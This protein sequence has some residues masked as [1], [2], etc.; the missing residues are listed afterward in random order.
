[1]TLGVAEMVDFGLGEYITQHPSKRYPI[2]TR[3]NAGEVWPEVAYPLTITLTRIVGEEASARAAINAGVI[4][5][6]DILE[7]PSCFGGVFA[8]YMYL[9]LSFGRMIAVRTPGTTIEKSDATYYGSEQ[10]APAYTPHEDDKSFLASIKLIRYGWKMLQTEKISFLQTDRQLVQEW[11]ERLQEILKATDQEL[12]SA[13]REI[14]Q[15]AMELFTNHL[16]VTG[17]AG[18]A[19]Q[20]LST[21]C[22]DRLE[23]R[24]LAL[25]LLGNLGD[26]DSAAPSFA[27][28]ELGQMVANNP[29][30]TTTFNEGINGLEKRLRQ[31][32]DCQDFV[33]QFDLFLHQFGSRGPNEW[34][35]A[36]ETWGT[37]PSSVLVLIDRMRFADSDKSPSIR[38][39]KL[40]HNREQ[41]LSDARSQLKGLGLWLFNKSF[42]A[43][44]LFS[45][46]RERSKT[47]IIDLIHVARLISRELANRTV[48][49]RENGEI[50]DLWFVLE[51]E[52]DE[53]IRNP[54]EFDAKI[55]DRKN[56]RNELSKR[57]PP[58]IFEGDLPDPSTWPIRDEQD[59]KEYPSLKVGE[60]LEGFGG[61]PGI[62]E[63]TAR[64]VKDPTNP[65]TL[66]PGDILVAPLTDPSWTPLFVPAEAVVVDVGGQMSHAVIVSRELGMP[67]VV[68]VTDATQIIKDGSQIRVNGASG[69]VT[70][71]SKPQE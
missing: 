58:F 27:L 38:A 60:T 21:I 48:S 7:G 62:A 56:V 14:M 70:L 67:C 23:D 28:W 5:R 54:S 69:E 51:T 4:S 39:E 2:Y 47:T 52:L 30:L 3:G 9:N 45:Q 37:E 17:Q 63:G 34:E 22:E 25:T 41:A 65:G 71:L 55:S 46:A 15:P 57:I 11:K 64:I 68:A 10:Q 13:L 50:I 29:A 8:G 32:E 12:V 1:M 6:K 40:S 33:S 66:G 20:L 16:D 31:S 35:T 36:C 24:S 43:A 42:R 59:L 61:C 49:K 19:V 18:G 26:V 44:V 53:Y